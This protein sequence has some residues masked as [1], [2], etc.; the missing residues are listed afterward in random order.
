MGRDPNYIDDTR[1]VDDVDHLCRGARNDQRLRI[2][3]VGGRVWRDGGKNSPLKLGI[4]HRRYEG[5]RFH[6]NLI[7]NDEYALFSIFARE[8]T[9]FLALGHFSHRRMLQKCN[10]TGLK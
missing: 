5:L 9:E 10:V 4:N 8:L 6:A 1:I 7:F 2:L 3:W